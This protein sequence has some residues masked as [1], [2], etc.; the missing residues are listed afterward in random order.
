MMKPTTV[1]ELKIE[2]EKELPVCLSCGQGRMLVV[3]CHVNNAY[4]SENLECSK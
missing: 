4:L 3:H 1:P 2:K